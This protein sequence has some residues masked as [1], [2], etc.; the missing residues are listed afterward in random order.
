MHYEF[1]NQ[2]SLERLLQDV[3]CVITW[4]L[5]YNYQMEPMFEIEFEKIGLKFM[6]YL[7]SANTVAGTRLD[8]QTTRQTNDEVLRRKFLEFIDS[9]A[10]REETIIKSQIDDFF[11]VPGLSVF[12][13]ENLSGNYAQFLAEGEMRTF[14]DSLYNSLGMNSPQSPDISFLHVIGTF[15]SEKMFFTTGGRIL[16]SIQSRILGDSLTQRL[17]GAFST[18]RQ[19]C[20]ESETEREQLGSVPL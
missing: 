16:G 17:L 9:I 10:D 13:V 19:D 15:L 2:S 14:I 12:W 8:P 4:H 6:S 18:N 3:S 20:F 5:S 7:N 1:K 11:H